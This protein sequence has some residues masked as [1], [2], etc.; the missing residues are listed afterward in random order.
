MPPSQSQFKV[1]NDKLDTLADH[2]KAQGICQNEAKAMQRAGRD[3]MQAQRALDKA[4]EERNV[5]GASSVL[6]GLVLVGCPAF[7]TGVG[8]AACV[9]GGAGLALMSFRN[10]VLGGDEV[11]LAVD[12]L[13]DA[14]D[15]LESALTEV[16]RCRIKHGDFEP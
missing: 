14:L 10:W 1:W 7:E 3:V 5:N 4:T 16:C 6:G 12:E 15:D 13:G 8:A 9:F 11:D 2:L